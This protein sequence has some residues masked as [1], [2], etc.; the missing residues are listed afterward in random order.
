MRSLSLWHLDFYDREKSAF[1][2]IKILAILYYTFSSFTLLDIIILDID[3][4]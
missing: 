2:D 1:W 3:A 4:F